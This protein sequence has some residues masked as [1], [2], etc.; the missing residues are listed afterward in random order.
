VTIAT[1]TPGALSWRP[2]PG[3]HGI[4]A[5]AAEPAG[6]RLALLPADRVGRGVPLALRI[7]D[8]VSGAARRLAA[9]SL[10]ANGVPAWLADGR[11]ALRALA[12]G[13]RDVLGLVDVGSGRVST[14][15]LDAVDVSASTDGRAVAY[16]NATGVR[17]GGL[18]P[19]PS[20]AID[21]GPP[22]DG[23]HIGEAALD[24]TGARIGFTW[25]DDAGVAVR[26]VAC[27]RDSGWRCEA[28]VDRPERELLLA[29]LP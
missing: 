9:S 21:V 19:G 29:W 12:S 24:G 20:T 8:R 10:E 14:R 5:L 15:P 11:I 17:V 25:V 28:L 6:R 16:V 7:V 2:V 13:E 1:A 18:P 22:P 4:T 27:R 26:V 23:T 3:T